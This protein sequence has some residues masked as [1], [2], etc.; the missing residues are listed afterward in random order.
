M[1]IGNFAKLCKTQISVLRHYDKIGLIKPDFIDQFTGY[2]YYDPK[3]TE[4]FEQISNFKKLGFSLKDIKKIMD[5]GDEY[6][7][8]TEKI[9][10]A[11]IK[12]LEALISQIKKEKNILLNLNRENVKMK[13]KEL[14]EIKDKLN[15]D[16]NTIEFED[17]PDVVGKWEIIGEYESKDGFLSE[18][19]SLGKN[20][21]ERLKEIYFLPNGQ[22][23]WVYGW[24]KG[25]VINS[26]GD[27]TAVNSYETE[28]IN[29]EK[30]MF[31]EW[32]SYFFIKEGKKTVLVLKQS[33]NKK[34]TREEI[35]KKDDIDMPF[36][37]DKKI[38]GK[39]KAVAFGDNKNVHIR[40]NPDYPEKA[41][42]KYAEFKENGWC[43]N[44]Y[45]ENN[46][47][48]TSPT[49][50]WTKGYMLMKSG[51]NGTENTA[52]K[53]EI[54]IIDGVEYLFIEWK[55]GDYIWGGLEP[56]VYVFARE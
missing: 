28:E 43:E 9:F 29:G 18:S 8:E 33:D 13:S 30:Y 17:D 2:R 45:G 5:F 54:K 27:F 10:D 46:R 36:V 11:K 12:E 44:T 52:E 4:V 16:I 14:Y 31:A 25:F 35:S 56:A 48:V 41:F 1:R 50:T 20:Y 42:F 34:Y 39:W 26:N 21:G 51:G 55:S 23:Y 15:I 3:Q 49:V 19:K 32:K 37:D 38:L 7:N 22:R 47:K 6:A 53:Y 40:V 24:T